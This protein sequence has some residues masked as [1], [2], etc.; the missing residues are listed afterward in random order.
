MN[1]IIILGILIGI[2]SGII[3]GTGM[4]G[5]T[6][7][8]FLLGTIL[9]LDHHVAQASNLIFYIPTSISVIIYNIKNKKIDYRLSII[10]IIS[11]V[12]GAF[13][14][15]KFAGYTDVKLLKKC[16]GYFLVIIAIYEIYK[17]IKNK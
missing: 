8:I 1:K 5:G 14:G 15:A 6:I 2:I 9:K 3:S 13:L 10:I 11:G 12:I 16:F 4:G 7:L 17:L